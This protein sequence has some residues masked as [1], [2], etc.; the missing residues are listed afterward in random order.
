MDKKNIL[1]VE[2]EGIVALDLK[3]R[4]TSM[5]YNVIGSTASAEECLE[6]VKQNKPDIIVMDIKLQGKMSGIE[7]SSIIREKYN[8]PV[9]FLTAHNDPQTLQEAKISGPY[10]YILKPYEA[11]D[12]QNVIEIALYKHSLDLKVIESEKKFRYLFL[13]ASDPV[14]IF[15]GDLKLE[16][17][18]EKAMEFLGL[19]NLNTNELLNLKIEQIF[20]GLKFSRIIK[21]QFIKNNQI[22]NDKKLEINAITKN[23]LVPVEA[24]F[25]VINIDKEYS[26]IF[27]FRDISERK[28][29][30]RKLLKST[31]QLEKTVIEQA[32]EIKYLI[33]K[34]PYGIKICDRSGKE[35][36]SN[37][38][39][40]DFTLLIKNQLK[41]INKNALK[42]TL[43]D[44]SKEKIN[45]LLKD[46]NLNN[47]ERFTL[48]SETSEE[49][50]IVS[51]LFP[52]LNER[53]KVFRIVNILEDI[54]NRIK[55]ESIQKELEEKRKFS[56]L[57][58]EKLEE[59]RYRIARELHDNIGQILYAI[60]YGLEIFEN[61]DKKDYSLITLSKERISN[62]HQELTNIIY[63]LQPVI[64]DHFGLKKALQKL[65]EDFTKS[66]KININFSSIRKEINLSFK[67][68]QNIYRIIQEAL[69]N[70]VK[71]SR[72]SNV[73]LKISYNTPYYL[74]YIKDNGIGFD[75]SS[76][77]SEGKNG[78][79]INNMKERAKLI[80]G[81]L[82]IN[83][84]INKGTEILLKVPVE[85]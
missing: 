14:L 76:L 16:A 53:G 82:E 1:I 71:Y 85:R 35:I 23:G 68:K 32:T 25:S 43:I 62:I 36:F 2:D 38:S 17:F 67:I 78:F 65:L 84:V 51:N 9:V 7:A 18:N 55:A 40:K 60:K 49:I 13:K 42:K 5:G 15:N 21:E 73:E 74:F 37:R 3:K 41:D 33:D 24:T 12:L 66:T 77:H 28:K 54:T 8:I 27:I 69:N 75:T 83:S 64:L 26:V 48:R 72:A 47:S 44:A 50:T 63:S 52:L 34:F 56:A 4:L 31:N 81:E 46:K 58:I 45:L 61:S 57:I 10:G 30:E 80:N 20:S 11:R 79:G 70:I 22:Y 39:Y 59:E 6:L 19:Q 29:L